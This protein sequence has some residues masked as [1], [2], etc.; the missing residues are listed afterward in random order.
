MSQQIFSPSLCRNKKQIVKASFDW[1]SLTNHGISNQYMVTV[2]NKF[3]TPLET[4]ERHNPNDAYKN[5]ITTHIE[6]AAKCILT[7]P[8]AKCRVP[9]ELVAVKEKWLK[10][11]FSYLMKET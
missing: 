10:K 3:N 8:K 4:P 1:S 2:G 6:A 9:W 7:K 5:F 11:N